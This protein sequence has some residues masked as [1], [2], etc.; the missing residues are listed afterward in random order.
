MLVRNARQLL[1]LRGPAE[2]RRGA[3]LRDLGLLE[4]ASVL[5]E[6][7][8]I[9]HVG[10]ITPPSD[11]L[12]YDA[13][14]KVVLPGFVDSHTHLV[15]TRPRLLDYEMRIAGATYAAIASAG[16]GIVSTMRAVR[17]AS[18]PLL[19]E[20]TR[21]ALNAFYAHGTTTVEAKSGYGLD[22]AA[23]IK[24]LEIVETLR[25]EGHDLI[26]TY[27]GA[28]VTPPEFPNADDYIAWVTSAMLPKI[29]RRKLAAFADAFCEQGAFSLDQTRSYL[30]VAHENGF[31][32]KLH[33]EQ[34]SRTGAAALGVAMKAASVD[35]LESAS[36]ADAEQLARS[37]TIATLLPGA[38]FHLGLNTY[39]PARM[40][41]D[42]GA[43]VALATDYNPGTSPTVSMPMILSLACTQMRMTPAEAIAAA[44]INGA[45]ALRIADR[46][47]SIEPGKDGNLA[48]FDVSDY[49]E[50]P[51]YF[52]MNLVAA[53]IRKGK[54]H[55]PSAR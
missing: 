49:R 13:T 51:Y 35:H 1:T 41:I 20:K 11:A 43:A 53:T 31:G 7:D 4:N 10:D 46:V 6:N 21:D 32:L 14:G 24:S 3:H 18:Q 26:P 25:A 16:G 36:A 54:L 37:N 9:T 8:R 55:A 50:I 45:H 30:E 38:V 19:L 27:L 12:E 48:I 28:H 5:I 29:A 22:E 23:E 34:F 42:S 47:G 33:A 44:T 2:P 15:W 39:P 40:L 52:G 17:E